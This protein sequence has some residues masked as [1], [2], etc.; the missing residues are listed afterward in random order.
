MVG[1]DVAVFDPSNISTGIDLANAGRSMVERDAQMDEGKP[2]GLISSSLTN[3]V[4]SMS[5]LVQANLLQNEIL[6]DIKDALLGTPSQQRD[7]G[8]EA[9]ETDVPPGI[10]GNEGGG[11]SNFLSGLSKLNPFSSDSS[12]LLKFVASGL[13]LLGLKLFGD[14]LVNPLA[15]MIE[16]FAEGGEGSFQELVEKQ[17]EKLKLKFE[18]F[19]ENFRDFVERLQFE[20]E[21]IKQKVLDTYKEFKI[22]YGKFKAYWLE[23]DGNGYKFVT[24]LVNFFTLADQ[25]GDDDKMLTGFEKKLQDY[26]NT[27]TDFRTYLAMVPGILFFSMFFKRAFPMGGVPIKPGGVGTRLKNFIRGGRALGI[28]GLIAY[29]LYSLKQSVEDG[30]ETFSKE[31]TKDGEAIGSF[32]WKA[33]RKGI[34]D[35]IT[36]DDKKGFTGAFSNVLPMGGTAVGIVATLGLPLLAIPGAYP[37]ALFTAAIVGGTA[38][39]ITGYFGEEKVDKFLALLDPTV[40]G[41]MKDM[42]GVDSPLIKSIKLLYK[43][44]ELLL[45]NPFEYIFG[46]LGVE[47]DSF[48]SKLGYQFDRHPPSSKEEMYGEN[49]NPDKVANKTTAELQEIREENLLLKKGLEKTKP[50]VIFGK[51]FHPFGDYMDTHEKRKVLGTLDTVESEL[52]ERGINLDTGDLE[53]SKADMSN[54]QFVMDKFMMEKY[55]ALGMK[56]E[57]SPYGGS[58]NYVIADNNNDKSTNIK[59]ESYIG[60]NLTVTDPHMPGKVLAHRYPGVVVF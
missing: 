7:A 30:A 6:L 42:F 21:L 55:A 26:K 32:N 37:A 51:E 57:P 11:G 35:A 52:E 4:K 12:V 29:G 20:F 22:Q 38:G 49:I 60:G 54:S 24:S 31:L 16:Y 19:M 48:L 47:N 36:P 44:Y 40:D 3:M 53:L 18:E 23:E 45:L 14:R 28:V 34:S 1:T 50:I 17:F 25:K 41:M 8:V 15:K 10:T 9:G 43:S 56:F 33:L 13:A 27:L 2:T 5:V 58:G 39:L 59:N 46:K